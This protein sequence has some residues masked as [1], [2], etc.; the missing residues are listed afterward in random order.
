METW[1]HHAGVSHCAH[2]KTSGSLNHFPGCCQ[3]VPFLLLLIFTHK[4]HTS[5][6]VKCFLCSQGCEKTSFLSG[7]PALG[8]SCSLPLTYQDLIPHEK[9]NAQTM[10]NFAVVP[11]E[12]KEIIILFIKTNSCLQPS[13]AANRETNVGKEMTYNGE[14]KTNERD[15]VKNKQWRA[16][17]LWHDNNKWRDCEKSKGRWVTFGDWR[18]RDGRR[19]S[20]KY[21]ERERWHRWGMIQF[22][23]EQ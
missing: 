5:I 15:T 21:V 19:Q 16:K 20:Q 8:F 14:I 11:Q 17:A 6:S 13:C 23:A 10:I 18:D 1:W 22:L 9:W 12:P 4:Q 7:S 2:L 3:Y